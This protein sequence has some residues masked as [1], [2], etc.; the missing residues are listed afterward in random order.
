MSYS[1]NKDGAKQANEKMSGYIDKNGNYL[2]KIELAEWISG[3]APK[4]S[5]GIR[6]HMIDANKAKASIDLWFQKAD[7]TRNDMS[8]N[9]LDGL[10]T[11]LGLQNLSE[12]AL[13]IAGKDMN[14]CPELMDRIIG[15][16]IQTEKHAYLKDGE[17]KEIDKPMFYAV[18]QYKT[19][20]TPIEILEGKTSPVEIGK[21]TT[22]LENAKPRFTKEYKE[23]MNG[24]HQSGGSYG[25]VPEVLDLDSDLPF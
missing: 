6:I 8:A 25:G 1:L 3:Q 16:L 23:L 12:S 17:V 22:M 24:S 4:R 14:T 21:L 7:G 20:L 19:N 2:L 10:M 11:C 9:M 13:N 15:A 5:R 18:Y